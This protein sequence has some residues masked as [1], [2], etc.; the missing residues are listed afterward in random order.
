LK[1]NAIITFKMICNLNPFYTAY[2]KE[3]GLTTFT[4]KPKKEIETAIND[5]YF[6]CQGNCGNCKACY[7]GKVP[8]IVIPYH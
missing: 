7:K 6:L 4:A 3:L 1:N 5:G 2:A 8:K